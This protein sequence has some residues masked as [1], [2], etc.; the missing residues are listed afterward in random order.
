MIPGC[1][2]STAGG[3]HHLH[4]VRRPERSRFSGE[5][6]DLPVRPLLLG[7]ND[8]KGTAIDEK[9]VIG[10]AMAGFQRKLTNRYTA[11]SRQVD[12]S[13]VLDD[14]ARIG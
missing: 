8:S 11:T 12:R 6:K 9:Q 2:R 1:H 14:P 13:F 5:V 10:F 7:F 4:Q 3:G